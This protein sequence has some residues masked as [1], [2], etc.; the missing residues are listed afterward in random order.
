MR[1]L[2]KYDLE[3]AILFEDLMTL[4]ENYGV[5]GNRTNQ[6]ASL[7]KSNTR[8]ELPIAT[9]SPR[10]TTPEQELSPEKKPSDKA[11]NVAVEDAGNI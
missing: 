8:S 2:G 5:P 9:G 11:E 7:D 3:N 1:V 10:P 6:N 4:L